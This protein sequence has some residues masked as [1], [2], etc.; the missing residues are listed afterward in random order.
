[1]KKVAA[2]SA[3]FVFGPVTAKFLPELAAASWANRCETS[4]K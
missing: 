3:F 2:F 4:N 1:M